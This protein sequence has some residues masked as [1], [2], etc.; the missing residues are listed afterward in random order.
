MK[1]IR[2]W[3]IFDIEPVK[4][5]LLAVMFANAAAALMFEQWI[6]VII[7]SIVDNNAIIDHAKVP[8]ELMGNLMNLNV[9]LAAALAA[10]IPIQ[11]GIGVYFWYTRR[12]SRS[13]EYRDFMQHHFPG[14]A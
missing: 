3:G 2:E 12:K 9:I 8:Y 6:L 7:L 10:I 11:I 1:P 5:I 13:I 4:D 14:R